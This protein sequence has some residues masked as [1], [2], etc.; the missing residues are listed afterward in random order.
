[1]AWT[2]VGGVD[3]GIHR[4]WKRA[5]YACRYGKGVSLSEAL[6]LPHRDLSSLLEALSEIVEEENKANSGK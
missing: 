4:I 3:E 5:A 1:M 2:K 6:R